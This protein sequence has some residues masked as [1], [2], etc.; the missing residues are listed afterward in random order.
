MNSYV[1]LWNMPGY[2]PED[3]G[4]VCESF[5]DAKQALIDE[6]LRAADNVATWADSDHE[7]DDDCEDCPEQRAN[8]LALAA[9]DVNLW[10]LL[11]HT[12]V[13]V[14]GYAWQIV[15]SELDTLDAE[16]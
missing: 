5:A 10:T 13:Y 7:C 3:E 16:D 1:A 15:E 4:I 12:C 14:D 2:L 11:S 9:E 6:L 8:A